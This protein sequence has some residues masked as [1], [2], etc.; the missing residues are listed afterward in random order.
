[1]WQIAFVTV[2]H[3]LILALA[4]L[5]LRFLHRYT[6]SNFLHCGVHCPTQLAAKGQY[7]APPRGW[8]VPRLIVHLIIPR[9]IFLTA[10]IGS[11]LI[12]LYDF[13]LRSAISPWFSKPGWEWK[14]PVALAIGV[15]INLIV[16][17]ERLCSSRLR[18][19][20]MKD[21][22][23]SHAIL[24]LIGAQALQAL[25]PLVFAFL[26]IPMLGLPQ[27]VVE[28]FERLTLVLVIISGPYSSGVL[29]GGS[30][31]EYQKASP[32]I[33]A[34]VERI[35]IIAQRYGVPLKAA[36]LQFS[37]AHPAVAA[38]I[39]GASRPERIAEDHAALKAPIPEDFWYELRKQGLVSP[40]AP[41]PID[42]QEFRLWHKHQQLSIF[43]PHLTRYGS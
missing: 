13:G 9:L 35:K 7:E 15:L 1:M 22:E 40:T 42:R 12:F 32:E 3:L 43:R 34:K 14:L 17:V 20:A 27:P 23:H 8:M 24:M 5:G 11:F 33:L 30:H 36:A 21:L 29:A 10:T 28:F 18:E 26:V 6:A 39:P 2:G 41:L 37:L 31:F 16:T 38:V 4:L 25:L 19:A